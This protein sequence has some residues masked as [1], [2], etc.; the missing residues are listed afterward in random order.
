MYL[1]PLMLANSK[2]LIGCLWANRTAPEQNVQL[3]YARLYGAFV[4]LS[5]TSLTRRVAIG[6]FG[7]PQRSISRGLGTLL[8]IAL[9]FSRLLAS[10]NKVI[11]D[12]WS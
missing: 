11:T 9:T 6:L 3:F 12:L 5:G 4:E 10:W 2:R 7:R 1:Q 8:H